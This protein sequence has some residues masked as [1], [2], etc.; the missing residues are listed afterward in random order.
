MLCGDHSPLCGLA[1]WCRLV[2][3]YAALEIV[4][5]VDC[6]DLEESSA[7]FLG[8]APLKPADCRVYHVDG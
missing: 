6:C 8:P 2:Q 4:F 1:R 7:P 5:K 3:F